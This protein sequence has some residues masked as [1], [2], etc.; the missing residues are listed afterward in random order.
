MP[1]PAQ[2]LSEGHA[3]SLAPPTLLEQP[4][5]VARVNAINAYLQDSLK[6]QRHTGQQAG[7]TFYEAHTASYLEPLWQALEHSTV[8]GGKR[9]RPLLV[10]EVYSAIS[11]KPFEQALPLAAAVELVHAQSLV[12]DDLPC[13]DND[14]FRRGQPSVHYAYGEMTA[15]LSADALLGLAFGVLSRGLRP[16]A[17]AATVLRLSEALSDVAALQGLVSGQYADMVLANNEAPLTLDDVLYIYRNK[18]AAL[19]RYS[20]LAPALLAGATEAQ[21]AQFDA[22]GLTLGYL[23]QLVDDLLDNDSPTATLGK[24]AGKDAAQRKLTY[25]AVAGRQTALAFKETLYQ[26]AKEQLAALQ[27]AQPAPLLEALLPYFYHRQT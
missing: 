6:Q 26:Q 15:I 16:W 17:D 12:L 21:C 18:T 23:F 20:L 5:V 3:S 22:L 11:G 2:P 9:L 14:N 10:L 13:M 27:L 7:S 19:L 8:L 4:D 24:T 1:Q 25:P